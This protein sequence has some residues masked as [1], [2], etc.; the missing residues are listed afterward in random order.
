MTVVLVEKSCIW[1]H[2]RAWQSSSN[3]RGNLHMAQE[4]HSIASLRIFVVE[5]EALICMML[6]DLLEDLGCTVAV[7][8]TTLQQ[9]IDAA[10]RD[11]FDLAILDVNL[12]GED[13]TPV[14]AMLHER[15]IPFVFSTGYGRNGVPEQFSQYPVIEKPFR[16]TDLEVSLQLAVNGC[17]KQSHT[18]AA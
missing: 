3:V 9:A 5:D 1:L 8:S 10:S 6:Q 11:D 2:S 18:G 4:D 13:I 14:S 7:V 16:D 15:A 17:W 12:H